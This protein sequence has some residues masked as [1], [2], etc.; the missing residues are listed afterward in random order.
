MVSTSAN[1]AGAEPARTSQEVRSYF[2]NELLIVDGS[3]GKQ[4]TPS[5]IINGLNLQ[6]LR[7]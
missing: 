4:Q 2:G 1:P 6:T 3:L 7:A 5:V